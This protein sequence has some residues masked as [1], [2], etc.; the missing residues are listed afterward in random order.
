MYCRYKGGMLE[1]ESPGKLTR[2]MEYFEKNLTS[3]EGTDD[4]CRFHDSAEDQTDT[5]E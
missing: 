3:L 4:K 2:W 1:S 5:I